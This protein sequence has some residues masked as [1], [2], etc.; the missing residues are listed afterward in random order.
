MGKITWT[1]HVRNEKEFQ[2]VMDERNVL[3]AVKRRKAN[4]IGHILRRNCLIRH[5]IEGEIEGRIKLQD[6]EEKEVSSY[7]V[8][9]R[10]IE[11]TGN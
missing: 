8:T 10:K 3:Q 5:F 9:L 11:D 2:R 6:D 4:L 1:D 7:W